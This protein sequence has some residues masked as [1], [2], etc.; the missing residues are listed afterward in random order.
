MNEM[1]IY[2]IVFTLIIVISSFVLHEWAH[3][4]VAVWLGD[5]TPRKQGR[6]TLNPLKH[7]SLIALLFGGAK[8][9]RV[10]WK[11]LRNQKWGPSLV[12][13]AGPLMNFLIAGLFVGLVHFSYYL[14]F[15]VIL[16][17]IF[18]RAVI[19]LNLLLGLIN[20]LPFPPLDGSKILW[21]IP[22]MMNFQKK[23]IGIWILC[24]I[25]LIIFGCK[26]IFN[27]TVELFKLVLNIS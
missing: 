15:S 4:R 24:L 6:L 23:Y 20:L 8:P 5:P 16:V 7:L 13:L 3:A 10:D 19:F 25:F 1:L 12:A 17:L 26:W 14:N 2:K 27:L 9:T 22:G 21:F 18:F 11:K